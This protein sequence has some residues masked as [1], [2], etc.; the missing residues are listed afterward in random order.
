MIRLEYP[1]STR[2]L[3]S[4]LIADN[5]LL[6]QSMPTSRLLFCENKGIEEQL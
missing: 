5:Y 3:S 2:I 4:Y 6:C 1:G